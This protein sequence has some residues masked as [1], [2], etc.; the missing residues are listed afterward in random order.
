MAQVVVENGSVPG[1]VRLTRTQ[2]L[3][4]TRGLWRRNEKRRDEVVCPLCGKSI[5]WPDFARATHLGK[6]LSDGTFN[7]PERPTP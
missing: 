5:C 1:K 4:A 6:H 2:A 7:V 3:R